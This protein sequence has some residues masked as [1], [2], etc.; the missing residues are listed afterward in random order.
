MTYLHYGYK[1]SLAKAYNLSS[2]EASRPLLEVIHEIEKFR[3]IDRVLDL[4]CG[5]GI[6]ES[7]TSESREFA[8]DSVDA[9]PDA[10]AKIHDVIQ[11]QDTATV[12][13]ITNLPS[14][15]LRPSYSAVVSW[16]VLHGIEPIHYDKIFHEIQKIIQ[17]N[18]VFFIAVASTND[19]KMKALRSV[20]TEGM[21]DCADIMFTQYGIPRTAPFNVHFF[22]ETELVQLGARNGFSCKKVESFTEPSG[23][24]HL[25]NK[26]NSYFF[27][28]FI[29]Q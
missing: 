8:F 3:D 2:R 17:K 10:I 24:A 12:I 21:N 5:D 27:A 22:S 16:R 9:D 26:E 29:R 14:A 4:G 19:W 25:K 7:H 13:D 11:P 20:N 6:L 18:G 1:D 23:Y 15:I 28:K